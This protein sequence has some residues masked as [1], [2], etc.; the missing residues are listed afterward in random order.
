MSHV[1]T[2]EIADRRMNADELSHRDQP[3]RPA[4]EGV[5]S[6]ERGLMLLHAINAAPSG[7]VSDWGRQ[8]RVPRSTIYRLLETLLALGYLEAGGGGFRL[9]E[10][11]RRLSDGFSDER[12]ID[13]ADQEIARAGRELLW[14]LSIFTFAAGAMVIRRTTHAQSNMSID[15][16]M[17]GR[18]MPLTET[19]AGRAYL[20]HCPDATRE[21][22]LRLATIVPGSTTRIDRERIEMQL[23]AARADG[24][25]RRSGGIIPKTSSLSVPVMRDGGVLGCVSIVWIGS[26]MTMAQAVRDLAP[27]MKVL[28]RRIEHRVA[29]SHPA[30]TARDALDAGNTSRYDAD[31]DQYP[32]VPCS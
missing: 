23:A 19:A 27:P 13:L 26:A 5:R 7:S 25:G 16:G 4:R 20:G 28:A 9:T 29:V 6:L 11:V 31:H 14:P 1:L 18:C 12:W 8:I 15:D 2:V 22:L 3:R 17:G 21:R 24:F 30:D 32:H 10:Q